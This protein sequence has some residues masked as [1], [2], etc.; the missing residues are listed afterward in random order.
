[1]ND[2]GACP[3]CSEPV[4]RLFTIHLK[5]VDL[6]PDPSEDGTRIIVEL[7]GGIRVRTLTGPDLPAPAGTG[8]RIHRCPQPPEGERCA[9]VHCR[10]PV[11]VP[12]LDAHHPECHPEVTDKLLADQ[13]ARMR[14][15]FRAGRRRPKA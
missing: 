14:Q 3:L 11:G 13:R 4:I 6:D 15:Q 7:D 2:Q 5:L 10:R 12:L 8:Y 1:M 9:S